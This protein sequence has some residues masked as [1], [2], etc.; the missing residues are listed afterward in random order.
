MNI[1]KLLS[2]AMAFDIDK[3]L[4][5]VWR[6]LSPASK[7][8]FFTAFAAAFFTHLYFFA[9]HFI[10]EDSINYFLRPSA[11][12]QSARWLDNL[13]LDLRFNY[14]PPFLIGFLVM[15][16]VALAAPFACYVLGVRGKGAAAAV[17]L[18][19]ATFPAIAYTNSYLYAADGY[20]FGM[21]LS[22][23]AVAVTKRFKWGFLPGAVILMLSLAC[24]QAYITVTLGLCVFSLILVCLDEAS[25]PRAAL[26]RLWR[27][28]ALG[29]LGVG[30]YY[31]SVRV[32]TALSGVELLD[33]KGISDMG[34]ISLGELPR[35]ILSAYTQT[36]GM[37][38]G[39]FYPM[40]LAVKLIVALVG[41]I[42]LALIV[43][44][45]VTRGLYRKPLSLIA[46]FALL[47]L[48]PLAFHA[49]PVLMPQADFTMLLVYGFV[50][51][52]LFAAALADA[53]G[54]PKLLRSA[55]LAALIALALYHGTVTEVY[56]HRVST[57]NTR[58]FALNERILARMEPLLEHSPQRRVALLGPLRNEYYDSAAHRFENIFTGFDQGYWGP[59]IGMNSASDDVTRKFVNYADSFFGM[60]LERATPEEIETLTALSADMPVWPEEGSVAVIDGVI[61]VN[62]Q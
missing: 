3:S 55:S 37:L 2:G 40:P 6:G 58:T 57:F 11:D 24:Y 47:A 45:I 51:P 20:F 23:L 16:F 34:K 18:F 7:T 31:V 49:I 42:S 50:T 53:F 59:F 10:N 43:R 17:G 54:L 4:G 15:L 13:F 33:Y 62:L 25:A 48:S 12:V 9:S 44:V 46:V 5:R 26:S 56:Y 41:L 36:L 35:Q 21:F 27:Y 61:V 52:F 14:S 39:R 1:K 8:A 32:T 19:M 28:L 60:R 29:G 30:L 38:R 22:V